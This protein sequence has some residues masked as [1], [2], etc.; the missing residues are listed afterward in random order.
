MSD[1]L[2]ANLPP[3][4]PESRL[5][6]RVANFYARTLAGDRAGLEYLRLDDPALLETFSVGYCNGSLRDLLP[7]AGEVLGQLRT[8]GILD[9]RHDEVLLGCVVVPICDAAGNIIGLYGRRAGAAEPR[10]IYVP[11]TAS[12][13]FNGQ[14]AKTHPRLW[15]HTFPGP[16]KSENVVIRTAPSGKRAITSNCPPIASIWLRSVEI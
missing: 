6:A 5:L 15:R 16:A 1:L 14:A 13:L 7:H 8:L 10:D 2:P 11:E 9:E 12:R 4:I 3:G